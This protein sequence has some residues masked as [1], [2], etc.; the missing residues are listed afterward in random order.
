LTDFR[1]KTHR[2]TH[3]SPRAPRRARQRPTAPSGK[4][5]NS[6]DESRC[7]QQ[8]LQS[9]LIGV[10]PPHNRGAAQLQVS[11]GAHSRDTNALTCARTAVQQ[12]RVCALLPFRA[13]RMHLESTWL[14][15]ALWPHLNSV[16]EVVGCSFQEQPP[17]GPPRHKARLAAAALKCSPPFPT[18]QNDVLEI[19]PFE[20]RPQLYIPSCN[21]HLSTATVHAMTAPRCL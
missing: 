11:S 19:R 2:S 1:E 5:T 7:H 18:V 17:T 3:Q 21:E 13:T 20:P 12:P 10:Q 14:R 15:E 8:V 9:R 4:P 16:L 6:C